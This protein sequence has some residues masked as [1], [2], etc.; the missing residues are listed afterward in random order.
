MEFIK[1][2]SNGWYFLGKRREEEKRDFTNVKYLLQD[3]AFWVIFVVA[4]S[5]LLWIAVG[6]PGK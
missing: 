6:M 3:I 1:N 2:K 4:V 5:L